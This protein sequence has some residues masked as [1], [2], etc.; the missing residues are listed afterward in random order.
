MF[1]EPQFHLFK[2]NFRHRVSS[3]WWV[4]QAEAG[5]EYAILGRYSLGFA[6]SVPRVKGFR[7]I[8]AVRRVLL[9]KSAKLVRFWHFFVFTSLSSVTRKP[10]EIRMGK[11]KGAFDHWALVLAAG[12]V[13]FRLAFFD[14]FLDRQKLFMAQ[15][16]RSKVGVPVQTLVFGNCCHAVAN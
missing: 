11:G 12:K 5:Q 1:R 15:Q 3:N 8:S 4:A 16:V 9:R 14:K 6:L 2:K 10:K 13:L 7:Y